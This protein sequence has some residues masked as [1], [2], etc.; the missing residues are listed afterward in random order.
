MALVKSTQVALGILQTVDL[1]L[2]VVFLTLRS[3]MFED[4]RE[5]P[6]EVDVDLSPETREEQEKAP[7]K[8][9]GDIIS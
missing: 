6:G 3:R 4:E 1:L 9:Q 8:V 7:L 5:P 2:P